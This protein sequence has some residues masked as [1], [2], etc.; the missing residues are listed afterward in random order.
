MSERRQLPPSS[1][2][3]LNDV[4]HVLFRHKWK[5]LTIWSLGAIVAAFLWFKTPPAYKSEA[6][7]LISY[8]VD[9]KTPLN[10]VAGDNVTVPNKGNEGVVNAEVEILKSYDL[11]LKVADRIGPDK[12]LAKVNGGSSREQA[13]GVINQG[14]VVDA[15]RDGGGVILLSLLHPDP[16]VVRVILEQI[17]DSYQTMHGNIHQGP[18]TSDDFLTQQRDQSRFLMTETE[19]EL[20]KI[21]A[22]V[23]VDSLPETKKEQAERMS[24]IRMDIYQAESERVEHLAILTQLTNR[25]AAA[26]S[27]TNAAPVNVKPVVPLDIAETY[28]RLCAKRDNL[29]RQIQNLEAA[30]TEDSLLVKGVRESHEK[31]T[32]EKEALEQQYPELLVGS[33]GQSGQ[34]GGGIQ[35]DINTETMRINALDAK[36]ALLNSKMTELKEEIAKVS[37]VEG[38][39]LELEGNR[40]RYLQNFQYFS[41]RLERAAFD[42]ALGPG[43]IS[44]INA[45]QAPTPPI[46]DMGKLMK[47]VLVVIAGAFGG[48]IALA[49]ALELYVDRSF[50]R[51]VEVESRVNA[52][53]FL[54]IPRTRRHGNLLS[55]SLIPRRQLTYRSDGATDDSNAR[56]SSTE[57]VDPGPWKPDEK[58]R[59]FFEGLRD[60]LLMSFELR[61]LMHNPKLIAITSCGEGAGVSTIASGLAAT[62]SEIG[63][64][65]VLLVDMNNVGQG[66]AH[67]FRRG[68]LECGLDEALEMEKRGNAMVQENLYVVAENASNETLPRVLH[69]RFSSLLPKLKASDYDYIIFDMPPVGQISPTSK[70]ARFMD[71]VFMVVEAEKTGRDTVDRALASLESSKAEVG[72]VL[73]KTKEYVPRL[74]RSGS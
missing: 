55:N 17:I 20:A 18:G 67:H 13:A 35:A 24:R 69:K 1:G 70:L 33:P 38:K 63:E 42:E 64:G 3:N 65:N 41:T 45:I 50:K 61:N 40:Q 59:P 36:I 21:K 51:A 26:R 22:T 34:S 8:I 56:E 62:L 28:R 54:S 27:Q 10:P 60:R 14:L 46:R 53:L 68:K 43:K 25:V 73:N 44:D 47:K 6:K 31:I 74:L 15:P 58:L 23:D 39:I 7:L 49:F 29:D 72:I 37:T 9:N 32:A 52:P 2:L 30:F 71:M 48:G 66:A 16:V 57:L 5:I 4:Y 11:A 19:K 12:V